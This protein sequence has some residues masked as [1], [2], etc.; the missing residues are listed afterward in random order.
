MSIRSARSDIMDGFVLFSRSQGDKAEEICDISSPFIPVP[1]TPIAGPY[2]FY[3]LSVIISGS[4]AAFSSL[5]ML[6]LMWQHKTHFS[7]PKEQIQI[8]RIC[9]FI[10]VYSVG[11]FIMILVPRTF[12]YLQAVMVVYEAY[13]LAYFFLL[14]CRILAGPDAATQRDVFLAPLLAHARRVDAPPSSRGSFHAPLTN[15]RRHWIAIFSC[16]LI[17]LA[18]MVAAFATQATDT[19]CLTSSKPHYAHI[20]L[21]VVQIASK[22]AAVIG[23]VFTYLPL[24]REFRGHRLASKLWAFKLLVFLQ[25]VQTFAFSLVSS[26]NGS[27]LTAA[28]TLS[29][30]DALIGLPLLLVSCELTLFAVFFHYAYGTALYR[31]T[32]EQQQAGMTYARPGWKIWVEMLKVNDLLAAMKF[33]FVIEQEVRRLEEEMQLRSFRSDGAEGTRLIL[34]NGNDMARG[35]PVVV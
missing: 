21:Q 5:A 26:K 31:L 2:D 9:W 11:I 24:R 16:P 19:Y 20:Y 29:R 4:C 30:I 25:V 15:F 13:A 17:M 12:V 18:V 8:L 27:A 3:H 33:M 22:V 1:T 34:K 35:D 14:M 6:I 28:G 32:D 7:N 23:V 10:A